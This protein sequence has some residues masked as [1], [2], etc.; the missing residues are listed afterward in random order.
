MRWERQGQKPALIG[1]LK[2]S[3]F[4]PHNYCKCSLVGAGRPWG[5]SVLPES[6]SQEPEGQPSWDGKGSLHGSARPG[7]YLEA[8]VLQGWYRHSPPKV[9]VQ[10]GEHG[11]RQVACAV[12]PVE[13]AWLNQVLQGS[14][15]LLVN[16]LQF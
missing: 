2:L 12:N 1:A 13:T 9:P 7:L 4:S 15:H 14:G 3:D 5:A 10:G 16:K 8:A 6:D 11:L